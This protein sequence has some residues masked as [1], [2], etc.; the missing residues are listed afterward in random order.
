MTRDIHISDHSE[1]TD[2]SNDVMLQRE[3]QRYQKIKAQAFQMLFDEGDLVALI[4]AMGWP[5]RFYF[6]CDCAGHVLPFY[7]EAH[8]DPRPAYTLRLA[9][10]RLVD[11]ATREEFNDAIGGAV[12]ATRMATGYARTA[13]Y[14]TVTI[15]N[16]EKTVSLARKAANQKH[17]KLAIAESQWQMERAMHYLTR[18]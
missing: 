14:T 17:F 18:V 15:F 7:Y 11:R 4:N 2:A 8:T 16:P 13:A 5:N 10:L 6:S 1:R 9:R 3:V 12:L